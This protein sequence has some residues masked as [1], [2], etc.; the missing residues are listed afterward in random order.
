[1]VDSD[2]VDSDDD[3]QEQPARR[4]QRTALTIIGL[5]GAITIGF[6][7]GFLVR[8]P[9]DHDS[10]V[11]AADSVDVG[12]AQDMAV[13]HAQAVEMA[14]LTMSNT[15][16]PLVRNLAYDI[17]TTQQNQLGQMQ[18]WLSLWGR[19]PVPPGKYMAWMQDDGN[20]GHGGMAHDMGSMPSGGVTK[21][22][23]MA[24]PEEISKLRATTGPAGD[25]LFLQLMLRHHQGGLAMM[26]YAAAHAEVTS[27]RDLAQ[28]MVDTQQSEAKL[29]TD[30]LG[31]RGAQPLPMN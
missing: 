27:V 7:I 6:A 24:T 22:P 14:S 12:F 28:T 31:Q 8:I 15:T 18:G 23:G 11:P 9:L 16:D 19:S 2:D 10:D 5:I 4:S 25:I 30:M 3:G 1:M 17:L 21:M 13:H 20:S 29:M 26:V